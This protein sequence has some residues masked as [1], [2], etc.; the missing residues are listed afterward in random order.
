[1][2]NGWNRRTSARTGWLELAQERVYS[3]QNYF[4]SE[5]VYRYL[6]GCAVTSDVTVEDFYTLCGRVVRS[7]VEQLILDLILHR[8]GQVEPTNESFIQPWP[9][10]GALYSCCPALHRYWLQ[11][12]ARCPVGSRP[13][14]E[15]TRCPKSTRTFRDIG[16]R[17]PTSIIPFFGFYKACNGFPHFEKGVKG[18]DFIK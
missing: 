2:R 10:R 5:Y 13:S 11:D 1:M 8:A 6:L 7:I 4:Y 16:L 12:D 3:S 14:S 9:W 18:D 17:Y 15:Y